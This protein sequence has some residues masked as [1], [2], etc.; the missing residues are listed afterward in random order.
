M[1]QYSDVEPLVTDTGQL[2]PSGEI[3]HMVLEGLAN[4]NS[5]SEE[6]LKE[7]DVLDWPAQS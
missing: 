2:I 4:A 5:S 7:K 3:S 1:R 6:A